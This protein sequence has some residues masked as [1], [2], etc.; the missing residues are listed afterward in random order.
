MRCDERPAVGAQES[1]GMPP[2]ASS[3]QEPAVMH[4][5]TGHEGE[6]LLCNLGTC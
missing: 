5:L 4:S 2:L 6:I 3:V 1:I